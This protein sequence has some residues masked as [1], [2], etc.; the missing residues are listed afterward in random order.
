MT[1]LNWNLAPGSASPELRRAAMAAWV[2]AAR[3]AGRDVEGFDPDASAK[4]QIAWA[5]RKGFLIAAT[6]SRFSTKEQK[7]TEAQTC[8]CM[9]GAA[10]KGYFVPADYICVDE[11]ISGRKNRRPGLD[12]LRE[13]LKAKLLEGVFVF[14]ISRLFRSSCKG[15]A[16]VH[17]E[18]FEKNVRCVAVGQGI[19]TSDARTW[20]M[21]A[22]V[23]GVM[24]EALI[25]AIADHVRVG[26]AALHRR[27]YVTGALTVGYERVIVEGQF[28]NLGKPR[29]VPGVC[30]V[31]AALIVKAYERVRDGMSLKAAFRLYVAEGGPGDPRSI[32]G[33]MTYRAFRRLLSNPRYIGLWYFGKKR[34]RFR[35][36]G[37]YVGQIDAPEDEIVLV[38]CEEL[39]IVSD[40][41]FFAVQE[42][43]AKYKTGSR[44]PRKKRKLKLWDYVLECFHCAACKKKKGGSRLHIAGANGSGGR[45]KHGEH[46]P[47]LTVVNRE[48]AV[49]AVCD[50]LA[51][52]ILA[53]AD[54]LEMTLAYAAE[55]NAAGDDLLRQEMV[56]LDRE[57]ERLDR[58][59]EDLVDA[60]GTA[61]GDDRVKWR[62]RVIA[63]QHDLAAVREE[64]MRVQAQFDGVQASITPEQIRACLRDLATLL[65]QAAAGELGVDETLRAARLFRQLTGERILVHVHP[66]PGKSDSAVQGVFAPRIVQTAK[67]LLADSRPHAE[68]AEEQTVW[69]RKPPLPDLLAERVHELCDVLKMPREEVVA[70]LAKEG[71]EVRIE[72]IWYYRRRYWEM[73]GMTP[74]PTEYNNGRKRR[75]RA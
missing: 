6:I 29:T 21:L 19:D 31:V 42:K 34:N 73:Q 61:T 15:Y 16:F 58:R 49:Q 8:E 25:D 65:R 51:A 74:P 32:H 39:R 1:V 30:Q 13:L 26:L 23:H 11:G 72:R 57:I 68:A 71:H 75:K 37:D 59:V 41:L 18:L 33:R 22:Q 62:T 9:R 45:C 54:L 47:Q 53:D 48:K 69:L 38:R 28:T 64:R 63:A 17:G 70:E 14:K 10:A 35:T 56:R 52:L 3:A 67:R 20:K 7:S 24:D 66:R 36:E 4:V 5:R 55:A 46:C 50:R 44:S 40:E 12:K 27:G 60:A 43:L 2:E